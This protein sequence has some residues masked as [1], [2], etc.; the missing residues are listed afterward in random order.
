MGVGDQTL[1]IDHLI[2]QGLEFGNPSRAGHTT[3]CLASDR[4]LQLLVNCE[5]VLFSFLNHKLN[6]EIRTC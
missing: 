2:G 5:V 3:E 4:P 1:Q 6:K